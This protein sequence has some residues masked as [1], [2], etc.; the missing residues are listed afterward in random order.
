MRKEERERKDRTEEESDR[1][2]KDEKEGK[3]DEKG[4][5]KKN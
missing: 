5:G 1:G 2:W 3:T 4:M